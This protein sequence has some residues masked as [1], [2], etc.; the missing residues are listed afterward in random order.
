MPDI[1]HRLG[2]GV[3][4]EQ[5]MDALTTLDG[6]A[7]WWTTK[8]EG[9][10]RPGGKLSFY[11]GSPEPSAVMEVQQP[12]STDAVAWRVMEGPDSWVGTTITFDLRQ[13]ET[14]T[15]VLFTHAGWR[16]PVE[17]MHHCST[18]WGYF[19]LGMK[20]SLEGGESV[21]YPKDMALSSWR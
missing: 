13:E 4:K 9:D 18:K 3:P 7:S 20:Q 6:I 5:V 14:E 16:E 17:F 10:A 8:L 2:I 15:I 12:A 1:R 21:A 19:I 11:F